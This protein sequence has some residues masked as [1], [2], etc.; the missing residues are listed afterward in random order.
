[1]LYF[2]AVKIGFGFGFGLRL[3]LMKI[4]ERFITEL[5]PELAGLVRRLRMFYGVEE[6]LKVYIGGSEMVGYT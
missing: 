1:M 6:K 5:A 3:P 4:G 2:W